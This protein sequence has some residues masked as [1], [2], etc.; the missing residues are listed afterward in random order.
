MR[1]YVAP[2]VSTNAYPAVDPIA[3]TLKTKDLSYQRAGLT[4]EEPEAELTPLQKTANG[5]VVPGA[6]PTFGLVDGL[7]NIGLA[8]TVVFKFE[9][10]DDGLIKESLKNTVDMNST[11]DVDS[12]SKCVEDSEDR[13]DGTRQRKFL[14]DA[15]KDVKADDSEVGMKFYRVARELIAKR[16]VERHLKQEK[17]KQKKAAKAIGTHFEHLPCCMENARLFESLQQAERQVNR[18]IN[19]VSA[20]N[21]A[22]N[23]EVMQL[24]AELSN[25]RQQLEQQDDLLALHD[26]DEPTM[27]HKAQ[28]TASSEN[29]HSQAAEL[30]EQV[31]SQDAAIDQLR[32]ATQQAEL[33]ASQYRTELQ[34]LRQTHEQE[35]T[36]LRRRLQVSSQGDEAARLQR[37]VKE[38]EVSL[39]AVSTALK[40]ALQQR[41]DTQ[42]AL[43]TMRAQHQLDIKNLKQ[44]VDQQAAALEQ[45]SAQ[46]MQRV[47]QLE[48]EETRLQVEHQKLQAD[49]ALRELEEWRLMDQCAKLHGPASRLMSMFG[50]PAAWPPVPEASKKDPA[51]HVPWME[52]LELSMVEL[53]DQLQARV[54]DHQC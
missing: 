16:A 2:Y 49:K 48:L 6:L 33:E 28:L 18:Q 39:A 50:Q 34:T 22:R 35:V 7:S 40:G 30:R 4:F 24:T 42:Q 47:H 25:L 10:E 19:E 12:W 37:K 1:P 45:A 15:I 13:H 3:A 26:S 38:L 14:F 5:E 23:E 46:T 20:V 29:A 27:D 17:R 52:A 36:D 54:Q 41:E 51:G 31:A 44:S 43:R 11:A 9:K 32:Q 53:Y 21:R 8:D